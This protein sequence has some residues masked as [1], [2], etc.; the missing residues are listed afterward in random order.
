MNDQWKVVY[1]GQSAPMIQ[2]PSLKLY[3]IQE[4]EL[5]Q[6]CISPFEPGTSSSWVE[7]L[8]VFRAINQVL[9]QTRETP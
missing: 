3:R 5:G 4:L 1:D 8:N 7:A 9:S 2:S 6:W